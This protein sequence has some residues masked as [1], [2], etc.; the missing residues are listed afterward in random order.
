MSAGDLVKRLRDAAD[1]LRNTWNN[2]EGETP[3]VEHLWRYEDPE[4][5]DVAMKWYHDLEPPGELTA[6]EAG[7]DVCVADACVLAHIPLNEGQFMTDVAEVISGGGLLLRDAADAIEGTKELLMAIWLAD[8]TTYEHHEARKRDGKPPK[9][10]GG[11]RWKTPA[12]LAHRGLQAMGVD[13]WAELAGGG[14]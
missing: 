12:E 5:G 10:D 1:T 3:V 9:E 4:R 14:S 13:P 6:Y 11:T 2:E 7:I 8:R